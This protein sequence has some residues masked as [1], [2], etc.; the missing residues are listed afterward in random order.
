MKLNKKQIMIRKN[1]KSF[2]LF[3]RSKFYGSNSKI[4]D[5]ILIQILN[6]TKINS[7]K[8]VCPHLGISKFSYTEKI[9]KENQSKII[10]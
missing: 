5:E 2:N 10:K 9:L 4:I 7:Y 3:D 1:L 8:E 6:F